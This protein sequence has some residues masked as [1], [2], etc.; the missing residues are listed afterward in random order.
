MGP[1]AEMPGGYRLVSLDDIDSTNAEAMRRA[2]I[3]EA[4]RLWVMADRQSRGKGRSGRSWASAPGNLYASLILRLSCG[5]EVAQ[6]LAL[7]AGVA[8]IDAVRAIWAR[9]AGSD[10]TVAVR[11]KW[12]NDILAGSAKLGGILLESAK[13]LGGPGL[14]TIIGIGLNI[15]ASP[16]GLGRAV[17]SLAEQG[18]V[19]DRRNVLTHLAKSM[20][21]ALSVWNEGVGFAEIRRAWT[22][23][24][25]PLDEFL[26]VDSGSG[27]VTG[28]Y[29]GLDSDG[30][31]LLADSLGVRHRFTYGDVSLAAQG[32]AQ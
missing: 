27:A 15:E 31:L 23:R 3:G 10:R 24:A 26:T 1:I 11:L 25:G 16:T 4:G 2:A 28:Q 32:D 5:P 12:P 8:V 22:D 30:A 20:D 19:A 13:D 9:P 7:V 18:V 17:T 29:K 6:Q 14:V 21:S